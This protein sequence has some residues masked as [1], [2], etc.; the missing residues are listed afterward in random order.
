MPEL[1]PICYG[2]MSAAPFAF[3]RG[4]AY[5]M[6]SDLAGSSQTGMGSTL[7]R[8]AFGQLRRVRLA[9]ASLGPNGATPTAVAH[10]RAEQ[11]IERSRLEL[12][13]LRPS[14]F[15]Q[16]LLDAFAPSVAATGLLAGPFGNAPIVM[17]D[18]RDVAA[19]A[20]AALLADGTTSRAWQLTGR[21]PVRFPMIAEQLGARHV[22]VPAKAAMAAM[23]RRGSGAFEIEH[24]RRMSS[25]F[26]AGSDGVATDHVLRLTG[27]S[28]RSSETFLAEHRDAFAR[29]TPLGL[30]HNT[31]KESH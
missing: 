7:R 12:T 10:R 13:F 31:T 3:Y 1:V 6:A 24:A 16:N 5:V 21:R 29:G 11:R 22:K 20:V 26:A 19:C 18:I 30:S 27:R 25:Y 9:G 28:P 2:R 23:C 4:A 15:M 17:V 14:F 8:C